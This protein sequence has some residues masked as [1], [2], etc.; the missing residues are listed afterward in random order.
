MINSDNNTSP[1]AKGL[2]VAIRQRQ[3]EAK[4][5]KLFLAI[6]KNRGLGWTLYATDPVTGGKT[7]AG[8]AM[9]KENLD[10]KVN[11]ACRKFNIHRENIKMVKFSK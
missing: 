4:S 10:Y 3:E 5:K 8:A 7:Y 11:I 2:F 6:E 1:V 9:S